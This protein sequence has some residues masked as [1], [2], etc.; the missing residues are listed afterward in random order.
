MKTTETFARDFQTFHPYKNYPGVTFEE[1]QA[2]VGR[3]VDNRLEWELAH[4][5]QKRSAAE[6][7]G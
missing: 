1:Y 3:Y 6:P 5:L 2:A 4:A 7:G